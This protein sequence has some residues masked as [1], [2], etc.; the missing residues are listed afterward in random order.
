[1]GIEDDNGKEVYCRVNNIVRGYD[2]ELNRYVINVIGI[3][4]FFFEMK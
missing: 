2:V 4:V 1:M 3:N